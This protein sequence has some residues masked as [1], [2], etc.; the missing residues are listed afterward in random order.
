MIVG[1]GIDLCEVSRMHRALFRHEGR[2]AA[3][4]FTP[5]ERAYCDRRANP[6]EHYAARFA[7]KE[8]LLKALSVPS[9]LSWHEIQI[10][11]DEGSAPRLFLRGQAQ[12]AAARLKITRLHLSLTHSG[13]NA[14]AVVIAE[15]QGETP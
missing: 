7:A 6:A 10:Q 14:A 13:D 5:E 9:G 15:A 11:S 1:V 2:L 3:R 8:A 4:L 12:L